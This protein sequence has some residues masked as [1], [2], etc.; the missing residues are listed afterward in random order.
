MFRSLAA[1]PQYGRYIEAM[2]EVPFAV[3]G[4]LARVAPPYLKC[5]YGMPKWSVEAVRLFTAFCAERG[6][7]GRI[8]EFPLA[9][10]DVDVMRGWGWGYAEMGTYLVDLEDGSWRPG[11]KVRQNVRRLG[12]AGV[13]I[14]PIMDTLDF[15]AYHEIYLGNRE[16]LGLAPWPVGCF[17]TIHRWVNDAPELAYTLAAFRGEEMLAAMSFLCGEGWVDEVHVGQVVQEKLYPEEG[18]R[19]AGIEEARRRGHRYYDLGGITPNAEP[20][21]K[22]EALARYKKKFNGEYFDAKLWVWGQPKQ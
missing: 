13:E 2:G 1:L 16:A 11:K 3:D 5:V 14:R 9:P 17:S 7:V 20:G 21:S 19:V 15:N 6:L 12:D 22:E 8:H 10:C 18:L 4:L